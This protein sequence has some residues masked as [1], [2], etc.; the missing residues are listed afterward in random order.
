MKWSKIKNI[1]AICR[2]CYVDVAEWVLNEC[3]QV[4][5]EIQDKD[6]SDSDD[7]DIQIDGGELNAMIVQ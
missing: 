4:E 2:F 6:F 5:K 1:N 7:V 3:V